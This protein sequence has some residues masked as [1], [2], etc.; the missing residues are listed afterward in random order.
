MVPYVEGFCGIKQQLDSRSDIMT[1]KATTL[2]SA[3]HNA[4]K[5][6]E[7]FWSAVGI[8]WILFCY[9]GKKMLVHDGNLITSLV[10]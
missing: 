8:Q 5:H 2:T 10:R 7:R 4:H 1:S 6:N 9:Y 3:K